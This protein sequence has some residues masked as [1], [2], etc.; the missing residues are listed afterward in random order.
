MIRRTSPFS[1][2]KV[3]EIGLAS[4]PGAPDLLGSFEFFVGAGSVA[5][6]TS[7]ENLTVH[8]SELHL[9]GQIGTHRSAFR[10]AVA[11]GFVS[12]HECVNVGGARPIRL[13]D[14]EPSPAYHPIHIR[15]QAVGAMSGPLEVVDQD[16][17]ADSGFVPQ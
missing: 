1:S 11:A 13:V 7:V 5:V 17:P 14:D 15:E 16:L 3:T 6:E 8:I 10:P 2:A 4:C 12:V 9:L